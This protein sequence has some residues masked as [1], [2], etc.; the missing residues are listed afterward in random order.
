[1]PEETGEVVA[2]WWRPTT[3]DAIKVWSRIKAGVM[4]ESPGGP[5]GKPEEACGFIVGVGNHRFAVVATA[6]N[7]HE[8]PQHN[9]MIHAGDHLDA[10]R[11]FG[12][13]IIGVWHSHIDVSAAMSTRDV[14]HAVPGWLYLI[15]SVRDDDYSLSVVRDHA[16]IALPMIV[17]P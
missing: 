6:R 12:P 15:Y 17:V 5:L 8:Q 4:P 11:Q 1:M 16:V 10:V 13:G 2:P 14:A 9:Y 3:L 7:D